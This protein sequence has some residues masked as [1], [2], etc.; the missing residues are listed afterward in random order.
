MF[1]SCK[2]LKVT[3]FKVSYHVKCLH[4]EDDV[5]SRESYA[6]ISKECIFQES[7]AS[8]FYHVVACVW[9]GHTKCGARHRS[10]TFDWI[11]SYS[12]DQAFWYIEICLK[13][14]YRDQLLMLCLSLQI[15]FQRNVEWKYSHVVDL[16]PASE[17]GL[18]IM[19]EFWL[20]LETS[21]FIYSSGRREN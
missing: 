7:R 4:A 12:A 11:L 19:F 21:A 9:H 10:T 20:V 16:M 2:E 5:H 17:N 8:T 13:V 18:F 6:Q 1:N 14:F 3:F 15:S